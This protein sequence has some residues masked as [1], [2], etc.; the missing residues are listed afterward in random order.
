M[1]RISKSLESNELNHNC[2]SNRKSKMPSKEGIGSLVVETRSISR[3]PGGLV[4]YFQSFET[5]QS[6]YLAAEHSQSQETR[7]HKHSIFVLAFI[8]QF[9]FNKSLDLE[10][11]LCMNSC[12]SN[13]IHYSIP[14]DFGQHS[15]P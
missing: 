1:E 4:G 3:S 6:Q 7:N 2:C 9:F 8:R 11:A 12:K 10:M 13:C 14:V 15:K 5:R